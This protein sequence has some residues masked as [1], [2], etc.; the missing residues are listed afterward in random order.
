MP[1]SLVPRRR[2]SRLPRPALGRSRWRRGT[3]QRLVR[4][5]HGIEP[6]RRALRRAT[7][8]GVY[9]LKETDR[10]SW[11]RASTGCC[12]TS[13]RRACRWW[14]PSGVV[15]ERRRRRRRT[16]P[17]SS[18]ASST[19]PS[20]T[21]YLFAGASGPELAPGCSTPAVVLLVRLHLDGFFWGDC[22]LVQHAVPARRRRPDGLP[23]GR[24]DGRA[25]PPRSTD[26]LR[27]TT[28]R[29]PARTSSAGC[30]TCRPP[31][32]SI[33]RRPGRARR[34]R[35]APATTASGT[36][37]PAPTR[38]APTSA[39]GSTSRIR[40]LN[41][42]GFDVEEL[43]V[44]P[45]D[46]GRGCASG[47]WWSRRATTA[48]ELRRRTGLEVQENQA[49]RLLDDIAAYRRLAGAGERRDR[50]RRRWPPPGGSPRSTSRSS[51]Q[52]PATCA[53][54]SRPPSC[55]HELLEHRWLLSEAAGH[56]VTNEAALASYLDNVLPQRPDER[57]IL[58]P[59]DAGP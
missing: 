58:A 52:V 53:A 6:P 10:A 28:S 16:A 33:R 23:G 11:P 1:F 50:C 27:R 34:R 31:A 48:G 36:S 21:A 17:C 43:V 22:S 18:P 51:Q 44:E 49:R 39:T 19:T 59:G 20:R 12:G 13:T 55:F 8:T 41:D 24:R 40:R 45:T 57:T 46:G 54:A 7:A 3:H 15:T 25:H 26:G 29:S 35:S 38:S 9:A 56:E 2:P 37:S 4:M 32:G 47:R 5:A 14:R 30:S 42:L